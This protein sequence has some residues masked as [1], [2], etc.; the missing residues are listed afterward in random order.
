MAYQKKETKPK[1]DYYQEVTNEILA[2][3]EE[4]KLFWQKDWDPKAGAVLSGA[5]NGKTKRAYT[6]ENAL[7]LSIVASRRA[8]DGKTDPRF[9][10]FA[11]AK[12]MGFKVLPGHHGTWIKQGFY[13]TKDAV[14]KQDLPEEDCHW[15]RVFTTV[16]HASDLAKK[17]EYERDEKG[18]PIMEPATDSYGRPITKDGA[19]AMRPKVKVVE[20]IPA[21]V[22]DEK[23]IYT[24]EE[25]MELAESVLQKSGAKIENDQSDRAYY[26]HSEDMIHLPKKEAFPKLEAY[27][28]TALH[29]LGHWTGHESR[30]NRPGIAKFDKFGSPQYAAEELRAE[31]A[32]VF[33]SIDTGLPLNK[34]NNAAYLQSWI[35]ELKNNKMEFFHAVNDAYKI[36]DYIEG[37]V[38]EKSKTK[39]SEEEKPEEKEKEETKGEQPT[40]ENEPAPEPKPEAK[41]GQEPVAFPAPEPQRLYKYLLQHRPA[42]LGAVPKEGIERIDEEDKGARYGAIYYNRK[43]SEKEAKDYELREDPYYES[44]QFHRITIYQT[45]APWRF[46]S[47]S[48]ALL[49]AKE[50][51]KPLDFKQYEKKYVDDVPAFKDGKPINIEALL[52][53]T[54]QKFNADDRPAGMTMRSVSKSDILR[55]D[56]KNYWVDSLGF[57]PLQILPIKD[58]EIIKPAPNVELEKVVAEQKSAVGEEKFNDYQQRFHR[59]F[60]DGAKMAEDA[61][62]PTVMDQYEKYLY[63]HAVAYGLSSIRP[64]DQK[65]WEKADTAFLAKVAEESRHHDYSMKNATETVQEYSPYAA[66]S[67]KENYAM[68]L[69][70]NVMKSQPYLEMKEQLKAE[71]EFQPEEEAV[72][73]MGVAR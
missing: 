33:L 64:C 16:F 7:R 71:R 11:Q 39:T 58:M 54:Y 42:D 36:K 59:A 67:D 63:D 15:A 66:V 4:G 17:F 38:R 3:M 22:P 2:M 28:G 50:E 41:E 57:K 43:L 37:L 10:T 47:L 49:E 51:G 56:E 27:Y 32:S 31:L 29:E 53:Q 70:Q 72:A 21:Y 20:P 19:P 52:E 61:S 73:S 14:T 60:Y 6:K 25:T 48:D 5:V 12:S 69:M 68:D 46:Q 8:K 18:E 23:K 9:F 55:I 44:E 65:A 1:R 13:A 40:K 26:S 34:Q 24:H 62:A 30:L 35:K 45:D